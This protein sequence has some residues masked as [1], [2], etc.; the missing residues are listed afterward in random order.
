MIDK[1]IINSP[2]KEPAEYWKYDE[3]TR[4]PVRT[5]GRRPAGYIIAAD[6]A[7]SMSDP[8]RFISLPLVNQLRERV[9]KWREAGYPGA[10][11]I[12]KR[13]LHHWHDDS[14]R[15]YQFFFCQL[16]A[17]ETL[18][19]ILEAPEAE[20][21]GIAIPSDGGPFQRYCSKLATGTGKTIVMAMLIAYQVLN[22]VNNH[23]DARFSKHILIIAPGLTVKNRL[24]VLHPAGNGESYY[25][26]FHI[27]PPGL[28][29]SLLQ[30]QVLIQ[31]W[32]ALAW[33]TPEQIGKR[34]TVDK[35][36]A[37][38]DEAYVRE[39]LGSLSRAQNLIVINDEAHHAWRQSPESKEKG[40]K[41]E[42]I[43]EATI[44]VGG[45]DRIH[46]ARG[47]RN[48]FD[49]SA[50]PFAPAG[51]SAQ[52]EA[53]FSWIVSD[54]GLNDAIEAGLVKTPQVVIRSGAVPDAKTF[55]S[56]LF[57]IYP[58]VMDDLNE[59]AVENKP[60][61]KLVSN[62]YHLLG[63]HWVE[64]QKKWAESGYAT[65]PVMI[66][67]ANRTE[68]AARI[69]YA[70]VNKR[71]LI[72]ELCDPERTLHIDSKVLKIVEDEEIEEVSSSA[73][74]DEPDNDSPARKL[75]KKDF[76]MQLRAKVDT[77]GQPG[78][79]GEQIQNVISVGMLTEGWDARTVTH[80]M[81]LRAFSS[82]LLC[83]QVVGRGLRRRSYDFDK[84]RGLFEPEYVN[85]F[86]IPFTF[87]PHEGGESTP[88][89]V[90]PGIRIEPVAE[91]SKYEITWPNVQRVD[92]VYTS[93]LRLEWDRVAVYSIDATDLQLSA[94]MAPLVDGKPFLEH[95]T[96]IELE[97]LAARFR[98]GRI[99][100]ET[101]RDVFES[102]KPGWQGSQ[103]YLMAQII[104]LVEQFIQSDK[105][106]IR[107]EAFANDDLRRR[108][109]LAMSMGDIVR[110]IW[111]AIRAH[112][113][114][115][116]R[117]VFDVA[118]PVRSTSD[119]RSWHTRRKVVAGH[120][121]HVNFTVCDS[122]YEAHTAQELDHYPEVEAWVKNDHLA[123]EIRY[124]YQG[125][126]HLYRPD[127]I[128]RFKDGIHLILEIKGQDSDRERAKRQAAEEW[129]RAVNHEG[130]FGLWTMA[131][132]FKPEDL[133][134]VL[135]AVLSQTR[136]RIRE[137]R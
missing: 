65:P 16:E 106:Q 83:E 84:E 32:H 110:H 89:P 9:S 55:E 34:R 93:V 71:I 123:F 96:E 97:R 73:A 134:D 4:E 101:A 23:A 69:R 90:P 44:W 10:T 20:K 117:A 79:P 113:A 122:S 33:D 8:G 82:Q 107:P 41:K 103:Q 40:V 99:A 129:C 3:E 46:R 12:T 74:E 118:H 124:V 78:K 59:K 25:D 36:G 120:R 111:Q 29:E 112:N 119:M 127:F 5:K 1:L 14:Q 109:V 136:G 38:S 11:G 98:L 24:Q 70:F 87:I 64:T 18:I 76:A 114:D 43:L 88:P 60:L 102:M 115:E 75:T 72:E 94:E 104:P 47:I 86:G 53:L 61:P 6:K 19:W 2:F 30:G 21:T 22:K 37:K 35:R 7:R 92:I 48:C 91:K 66:T 50:T 77:V 132:S 51:K 95:T 45:L 13:L 105:L 135:G 121:S 56:K 15:D 58:H 108:V 39:V 100:M 26:Q 28:H 57:H 137:L 125:E 17:I 81:G 126:T 31:N 49:F 133:L 52:E 42:D 27:V 62:A 130:G 67:V 128:V 68:T 85:I 116:Y 54:F 131:V 63:T 80:I